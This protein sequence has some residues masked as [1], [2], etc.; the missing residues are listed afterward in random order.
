MR[1]RWIVLT[2][3]IMCC[4]IPAGA[5]DIKDKTFTT[6]NAGKVTFSHSIH[7]K[8]KNPKSPNISCKACH[9]D[10]M[11]KNVHYTMAQMEQGKSCGQCHNGKRAFALAKCAACHKVKDI[12]FKVKETGPV[13]FKHTVHLQEKGDC[14]ACHNTL[15]K[16]GKNPRVSMADMEQGK[17]CGACHNGKKAFGLDK[18]A[19][20]HPVKEITYKVEATGPTPFSH[21]FHVEVA[22]CGKCH[23]A[24]Y[25]VNQQNKRVG[26]AAM[27]KGKSCGACH[28]SK[29]A[30]SVKDCSKCHPVRDLVF[31]DKIL[32]DVMFRHTNHTGLYT[33][34]DC[35]TSL[36]KATRSKVKV[37]MQEMEKGKSCG[38]CHDG[39]TAFSVKGQCKSC[40][41]ILSKP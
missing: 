1:L 38:A 23:P 41:Q 9:N 8:K 19:S 31:E 33:C 32:G 24:L 27:E 18:C 25:S 34:V 4:T 2:A 22:G 40:H 37:S 14:S 10:A 29:D 21:K 15:F 26:M 11:K 17:S 6:E 30:F 12:T 16:T 7:L 13:L 5:L 39:K 3:V 35:H 20:C 36:Y 28:N